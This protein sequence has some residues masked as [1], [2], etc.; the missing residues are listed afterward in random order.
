M[1]DSQFLKIFFGMIGALV[2]LTLVL[3]TIAA[4]TGSGVGEKL[5]VERRE[6]MNRMVAE[7]VQPVGELHVGAPEQAPA[8][9]G[10]GVV[11]TAQAGEVA[12]GEQVYQNNCS[13][14]HVPGAAGAPMLTDAEAWAPRLDKG[15]ETL[16]Q[17]AINGFNAMPPKGGNMNL[18]DEAVTAA[19]EYMMEQV[20]Q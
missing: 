9:G 14:C 20:Q 4:I 11:E 16:V 13:A 19:V 2:V 3:I 7:R 18:S 6:V 12:S 17:H 5:A 1:K 8:A 10:G 15:K